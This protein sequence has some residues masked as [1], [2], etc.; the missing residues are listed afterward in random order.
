VTNR[1]KSHVLLH[2][3]AHGGT[4]V[5][6][7]WGPCWGD[8]RRPGTQGGDLREGIHGQ[9]M[10][11]R[12][13]Y[14]MYII[15]YIIIYIYNIAYVCIYVDIIYIYISIYTYIWFNPFYCGMV[16]CGKAHNI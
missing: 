8:A 16:K 9:I 5:L 2:P 15:I 7:P 6:I 3:K 12:G 11:N 10:E 4:E 13:L 1:Y 14:I